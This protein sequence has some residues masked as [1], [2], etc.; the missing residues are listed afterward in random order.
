M[1]EQIALALC[2]ILSASLAVQILRS[3]RRL[4]AAHARIAE[5]SRV[6][7]E[8]A[9]AQDDLARLTREQ[10]ELQR[11]ADAA[12]EAAEQHQRL[13]AQVS[14][15]LRTP[16]QAIL[17][18]LSLLEDDAL[19][20]EPRRRHLAT[21]RGAAEDLLLL[22]DGLLDT[23]EFDGQRSA[24]RSDEFSPRATLEQV[25]H[26]LAPGANTRGVAVRCDLAPNLPARVRGDRLRLRQVVI[27][28]LGNAIKYARRG[29]VELR[30]R[31]RTSDDFAH[32]RVE[33]VDDG[34]GLP[35]ET[36]AAL[37]RPF[38]RGERGARPTPV[39]GTGLGLVIC[40]QLLESM[41]SHLE[42]VSE[43]GAGSTFSFEIALPVVAHTAPPTAD[44]TARPRILV[45]DDDQASRDLLVAALRRAGYAV[46][47]VP[48]GTAAV[49]AAT[50][51][52]YVA[53]VLDVQLPELDGPSA[54]RRIRLARDDIALIALTGHSELDVLRRCREAGI[55][56][57][58]IKP[59]KLEA[60]RAAIARAIAD[61][62]SP[63]DLA[64]IRGYL[65]GDDTAFVINLIDV[66]LRDAQRDLEAMDEAAARGDI[67]QV[68][69]LAH[70]LKGSAA[71]F[72]ARLLAERCQFLYAAARAGLPIDIELMAVTRE[73]AR[74]Q[75]ALAAE[76]A[77]LQSA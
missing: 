56:A 26:L 41:G 54:A 8:L 16:I 66:F 10:A 59:M 72:G 12:R 71:G 55:D 36:R 35:P 47:A 23:A 60:L 53:V 68:A 5:L 32:L 63:V 21:L 3:R 17:G 75:Q 45:A 69:A 62:A 64:V 30:A 57:V 29:N 2:A 52:S 37:F 28:L 34:P 13:V 43:P 15:E 27:N 24:L 19:P 14:H 38:A 74:V 6:R 18:L 51:R 22:I 76:R 7:G 42:C 11:R 39:E 33:I 9:R 65:T 48:D 49:S 58:L 50:S 4:G 67:E 73:F 25:V 31:A 20:A 1:I 70:R 77:R 44:D 61:R 40:Q 46:D